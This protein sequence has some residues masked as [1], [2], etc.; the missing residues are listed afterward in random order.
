VVGTGSASAGCPSGAAASACALDRPHGAQVHPRTGELY[1]S[2]SGNH[3]VLRVGRPRRLLATGMATGWQHESVTDAFAT[4]HELGRESGSWETTARTDAELVT[5][6][7]LE[8]DARNLDHFDA[9][10]FVTCGDLPLDDEQKAALLSFVR[11]DGKGFVGAHSAT[12]ADWPEYLELVGGRFD[13]HP[14]DQLEAGVRVEDPG[15]PAVRHFP[16]RFRLFDEFYQVTGFSRERSRV[17][18]SL[19]TAELDATRPGVRQGEI[20][21]AWAHA[22][23]RGRVF[24][25][26]LGHPRSSWAR[27]DLRRMWLEAVRWAMGL[28]PISAGRSPR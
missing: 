19:E 12:V 13:S 21:L 26:S 10:F 9:L 14:W 5:K 15:F 22:Y 20:P 24:C 3:R 6:R 2:D 1:V 4:L 28:D 8:N 11:D 25:S 16:E 18:L 17:L 7:K 27:A 23:G